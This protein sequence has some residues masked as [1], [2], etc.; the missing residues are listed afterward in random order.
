MGTSAPSVDPA[1][2]VCG[3]IGKRVKVSVLAQSRLGLGRILREGKR[4][5]RRARLLARRAAGSPESPAC[6]V[7]GRMC[8]ATPSA[9]VDVAFAAGRSR[10]V[11]ARMFHASSN[12]SCDSAILILR[13]NPWIKLPQVSPFVLPED[14]VSVG[15]FNPVA[16]PE[17]SLD[18]NLLPEPFLGRPDAPVVLLN[19]NPGWS[20]ED[21][22]W[23]ARPD[24]A[25]LCRENLL[26]QQ[27]EYPFYLLNPSIADAPGAR[28]W[29]AKLGAAIKS[30]DL[31]TVAS[32][33]LCVEYFPYHSRSYGSGTPRV[34]S[35]AYGFEL[36]RRALDRGAVIV[37]MRSR[38]RWFHAVPELACYRRLYCL[39]SPQNVS[40]SQRNCPD[41]FPEILRKLVHAL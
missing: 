32:S 18:T 8:C 22:A 31:A 24:F 36:V 21:A 27:A 28:W 7:E 35:Q 4:E 17:H 37:L 2:R 41:G 9:A 12:R 15:S 1:M 30:S 19:L 34:P 14:A 25:R 26:H 40:L 33:F 23:H 38:K 29:R 6:H 5:N 13:M 3:S 10:I 39:R 16:K 11:R 20:S